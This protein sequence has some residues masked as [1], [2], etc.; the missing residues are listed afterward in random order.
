MN[1]IYKLSAIALLASSTSLM[2]QSKSFEGA[3]IGV[4]GA[5]AGAEVDGKANT[6]AGTSGQT[7]TSGSGSIG[8]VTPVGGLDLSYAFA[9]GTSSVVGLGVSYIPVKAEIGVGKSNDT[10]SGGTLDVELKDHFTIYLQPTF[11]V[12]K[13]SAVFVKL[14][15]SMADVESSGLN[16][17]VT[18]GDIEGWGG[19]IGLKTFLTPNA[20]IQV[21]ANYTEYDTV[22]GT[23]N[24]SNGSVT[25]AS[26]DPKI[27]QGI[28]TLGYKF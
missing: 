19:G 9:T 22:S 10:S 14:N 20:F 16:A 15:Y 1:K 5:I 13:D 2:A 18:S 11:V 27:A 7:A 26:G 17:R 12:N 8:K 6:T 3:S 4:F 23:K 21:E 25:T 24:N 28:I